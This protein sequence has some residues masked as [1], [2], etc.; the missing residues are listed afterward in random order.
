MRC[1]THWWNRAAPEDGCR[2]A[3]VDAEARL[4]SLGLLAEDT[5]TSARGIRHRLHALLSLP[6]TTVLTPVREERVALYRLR[7]HDCA[8][9]E[10]CEACAV[11]VRCADHDEEVRDG[12]A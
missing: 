11:G 12:R 4:V 3:D 6:L 8:A 2:P 9:H 5:R 7:P 1:A 10:P